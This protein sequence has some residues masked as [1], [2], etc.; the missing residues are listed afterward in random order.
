[1]PLNHFV[2]NVCMFKV[3]TAIAEYGKGGCHIP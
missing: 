1:M 3:S 2:K